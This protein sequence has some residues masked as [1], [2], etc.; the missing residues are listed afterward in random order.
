MNVLRSSIAQTPRKGPTD[1]TAEYLKDLWDQ[2]QGRC[3]FSGWALQLPDS[4]R[5]WRVKVPACASLD[6]IDSTRGYFRGN[7]R[8][9]AL[10]ANYARSSF[11]DDALVEFCR[12]VMT[13]RV[14]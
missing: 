2:Q 1:L 14:G 9:V 4:T 8:F 12:A 5:K 6:R 10:M 13:F 3:P 7:V 11:E